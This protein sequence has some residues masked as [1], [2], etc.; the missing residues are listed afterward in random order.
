MKRLFS[1]AVCT[2]LTLAS[3]SAFAADG[4]DEE[5]L[6]RSLVTRFSSIIQAR[7]GSTAALTPDAIEINTV[8]PIKVGR[9]DLFAVKLIL[10]G[11]T[12]KSASRKDTWMFSTTHTRSCA[13]PTGLVQSALRSR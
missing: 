3:L 12:P 7:G 6:K 9:A 10:R 8:Q 5:N 4:L 13:R 11:D 2:M 1:L